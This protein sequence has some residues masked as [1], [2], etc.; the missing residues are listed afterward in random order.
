[1]LKIGRQYRH[2]KEIDVERNHG[3][4][5]FRKLLPTFYRGHA[6]GKHTSGTYGQ[7]LT[8]AIDLTT[9]EIYTLCCWRKIAA[10]F[11]GSS[12]AAIKTLTGCSLIL[13]VHALVRTS[14]VHIRMCITLQDPGT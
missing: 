4:R 10:M 8:S 14:Y 5:L 3:E 11:T 1:M 2:A 6:V 7:V 9:Q 12:L 13:Y